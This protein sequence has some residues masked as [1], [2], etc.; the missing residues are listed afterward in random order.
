MT[1]I[2]FGALFGWLILLLAAETAWRRYRAAQRKGEVDAALTRHPALR[3]TVVFGALEWG[4]HGGYPVVPEARGQ[5][6]R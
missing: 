1:R 3:P 5:L 2:A 6:P 4:D